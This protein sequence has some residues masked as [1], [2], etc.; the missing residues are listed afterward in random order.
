MRKNL[1]K[2]KYWEV[3]ENKKMVKV[4]KLKHKPD[5]VDH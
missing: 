3:V 4:N 2:F 1:K 5:K